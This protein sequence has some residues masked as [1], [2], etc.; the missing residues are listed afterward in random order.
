MRESQ[1]QH[2]VSASQHLWHYL[3]DCR[4][5][6]R[7]LPGIEKAHAAVRRQLARLDKERAGLAPCAPGKKR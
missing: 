7:I 2:L 1:Y 3:S 5:G 6:E 4:E